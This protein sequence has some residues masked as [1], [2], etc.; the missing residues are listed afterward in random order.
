MR[1]LSIQSHVVSGYVG[2][3]SATF[4]MQALGL[5]VDA[6]NSVQFSNHTGYPRV[7]GDVL[8]GE[9]VRALVDGLEENDLLVYT[10][11]LTGYIGSLSFL[12]A[13]VDIVKRIKKINPHAV[14]VCDPVLGDH[15]RL[16]VPSE[17]VPVYRDEIVP[18]AD[19]L[20]PNLFEVEQLTGKTIRDLQAARETIHSFHARGVAHVVLTSMAL[21]S[22]PDSIFVVGSSDDSNQQ[23]AI[24]LPR[25]KESF[26]GT[27]D[28][29]SALTLAWSR[30]HNLQTAV[31]KTLSTLQ[32]VLKRTHE[33][34]LELREGRESGWGKAELAR[35]KELRLVQSKADI[36][37]PPETSFQTQEFVLSESERAS[38]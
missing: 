16:Y 8:D 26:T 24:E 17:L 30:Y 19:I 20:T 32:A 21:D 35:S 4:P 15:G 31:T 1:V 38:R 2:N 25:L 18:L 9:R 12:R 6:I 37:R 13:V 27:G 7:E 29:F 22:A 11:I 28:L 36:E 33:H 14:Y 5:D 34:M 3:K 23:F 10:H